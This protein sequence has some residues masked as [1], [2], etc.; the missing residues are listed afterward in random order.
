M[1][2][3]D[4]CYDL[5]VSP[6]S[7]DAVS[8]ALVFEAHRLEIGYDKIRVM[9]LPGPEQGFRRDKLWPTDPETRERMLNEI[10]IPIFGMLPSVDSIERLSESRMG[11]GQGRPIYMLTLYVNA[12]KKTGR[13]LKA[14]EK[15][16]KPKLVT[17]T[18]RESPHWTQRNSNVP[19]WEAAAEEIAHRGYEVKIIRDSFVVEQPEN[20]LMKRAAL[21]CSAFCNFFVSNGPAW[22][23]FALDAPTV[24]LKPVCEKLGGCFGN[25]FLTYAGLP[26]GGQLPD[27]P[28]HQRIVW[29][30]DTKKNIVKAFDEF[31][32]G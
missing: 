19:E 28:K 32:S 21:Y 11:F 22:V 10:V 16:K 20:D 3:L 14:P 25:D 13:C 2:I 9:I 24:M 29:E 23:S 6:A 8:A 5:A 26:K 30:E 31:V 7:Y 18:L 27:C 4:C 1:K 15:K 12:L 17:I